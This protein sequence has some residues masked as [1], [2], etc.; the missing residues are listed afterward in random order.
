MIALSF[1]GTGLLSRSFLAMNLRWIYAIIVLALIAMIVGGISTIVNPNGANQ[2]AG[3]VQ[4]SAALPAL[5]ATPGGT[6]PLQAAPPIVPPQASSSPGAAAQAAADAAAASAAL[7]ETIGLLKEAADSIASAQEQLAAWDTD[8]QPLLNNADGLAIA[9]HK[10]LSRQMAFVLAQPRPSES[11]LTE[12]RDNIQTLRREA[13]RLLALDPPGRLKP[14]QKTDVDDLNRQS[15][16]AKTSWT[17]A[18]QTARSIAREARRQQAISPSTPSPVAPPGVASPTAPPAPAI[19][20]PA[21]ALPAPTPMATP[22][23]A[24]PSE[25]AAPSSPPAA[26]ATEN[27]PPALPSSPPAAAVAQEPMPPRGATLQEK[28]TEIDDQNKLQ[29]VKE[30]IAQDEERRRQ[31]VRDDAVR[32]QLLER[33]A[34]EKA[35]LVDE[36]RSADVQRVLQPFLVRRNVQPRLA[37]AS[38]QMRQTFAEEPMSFSALE[39]MGALAETVDGLSRLARIGSHRELSGPRW[40]FSPSARTWST[41][42]RDRLKQAQDLLRRLGPTLVEEKL[43]SP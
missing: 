5:P 10:D 16:E 24:L 19:T 35:K 12:F 8:I 11:D 14:K 41:D 36:A 26:I 3:I 23:V 25:Q 40:E 32:Q 33:Q 28:V 9:A 17:E 22:V 34:A 13:E 21:E 43:L 27:S 42:T 7:T 20:S 29:A 6:T 30:K 2:Q 4:P 1:Y 18:V 31:K 38:V 37:G 39:E 15:R